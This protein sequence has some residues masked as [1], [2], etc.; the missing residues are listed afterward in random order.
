MVLHPMFTTMNTMVKLDS[1]IDLNYHD[2]QQMFNLHHSLYN[3]K[4]C[5]Y[6]KI[7]L[8]WPS[9]PQLKAYAH[10]S[11]QNRR[12]NGESSINYNNLLIKEFQCIL[13]MCNINHLMFVHIQHLLKLYSTYVNRYFLLF[14]IKANLKMIENMLSCS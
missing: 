12:I 2:Y 1:K 4:L 8:F 3:I 11:S 7:T 14:L 13:E 10:N 6:N 9:K 5:K